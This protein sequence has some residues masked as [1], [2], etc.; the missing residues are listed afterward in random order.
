MLVIEGST[1]PEFLLQVLGLVHDELHNLLGGE[2]H[3]DAEELVEA[4]RQIRGQHLIT[5]ENTTTRMSRLATQELYF[6]RQI[7]SQEI[8]SQIEAVDP[9]SLQSLARDHLVDA[10]GQITVAV[11]GPNAP[12][13]YSA[14]L[15]EERLA[16]R[17]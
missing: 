9:S 11:V 17:H 14:S 16:D 7:P 4:K 5:S 6:G 2:E 12:K 8:L 10:L 1:A 3:I 15:I 13:H